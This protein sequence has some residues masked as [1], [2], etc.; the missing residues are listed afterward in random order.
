MNLNIYDISYTFLIKY[1]Q[2]GLFIMYAHG[3]FL[4]RLAAFLVDQLIILFFLILLT[5]IGGLNVVWGIFGLIFAVYSMIFVWHSGSTIGKKIFRLK[6]VSSNHQPMGFWR[7]FIR[8]VPGKFVS[9]IFN[10]GFLWVLIDKKRQAW[11]DKIAK[12]YVMKV[13]Q[14]GELIPVSTEDKIT[15]REKV[16]FWL[17]FVVFSIP[18]VLGVIFSIVYLFIA[19]PVKISGSAMA[20]GYTEGQFYVTNKLAFKLTDP[21]RGDVVIYRNPQNPDLDY[22]KRVIGIPGDQIKIQE[23]GVYING[24][25]LEEPYL[26]TGTQTQGGEFIQEGET[27][28]VPPDSYF[29]LGDNRSRSSDSRNFGFVSRKSIISEVAFCYWKCK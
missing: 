12:T 6:V 23:G 24:Q 15:G 14:K 13:D 8:E 21:K 5:V 27:V 10:L 25:V 18:L 26:L 17:L 2:G 9:G 28:I 19:S 11:H 20:P 16:A 3:S 29:I 1:L 7:T 4:N 22:I